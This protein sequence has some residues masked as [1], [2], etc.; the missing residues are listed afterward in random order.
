MTIQIHH[1]KTLKKPKISVIT[2]AL[3]SAATITDTIESVLTQSYPCVEHV[4]VD[5]GSTDGTVDIIRRM[6]RH[7]EGCLRWVSEP[8]GG[9]Y[10]AMNK[11]IRMAT[12]DVVGILNSDDFFTDE[13][14]LKTVSDAFGNDTDAVFGNLKF[15]GREDTEKVMRIWK[16]SPYRSFRKGWHPGHP[17]FY[18]KKSLYNDFGGFNTA[19]RIA[20]DFELM[21]RFIEKNRIRT[22]YLDRCLV[23]MRVG[24]TSTR[25]LRNIIEGNREVMRA[26]TVNGIKVSPL[27]PLMRLLPKIHGLFTHNLLSTLLSDRGNG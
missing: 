3:N 12:G 2:P 13:K 27:Y 22:R 15:V 18:A 7:Y 23:D 5:G 25:S 16:G 6:E 19:F 11:G 4:I 17:T 8:D 9:L 21:L 26:F 24:G 10:D 14:S 1:L 20:A